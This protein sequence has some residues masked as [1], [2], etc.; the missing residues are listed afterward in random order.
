MKR[1]LKNQQVIEAWQ[2]GQRAANHRGTL[3]CYSDG[4]LYSYGLHIGRRTPAGVCIVGD[5]TAPGGGFKSVTTSCHVG[6]AK[7]VQGVTVMHPLVWVDSPLSNE[8]I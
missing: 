3:Q 7:R 8:E 5:Y 2:H 1:I 6:R 4:T